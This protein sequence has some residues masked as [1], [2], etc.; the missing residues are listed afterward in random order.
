M[1]AAQRWW[2]HHSLAALRADLARLGVP[3]V[4][5]QGRASVELAALARETGACA[6]HGLHHY[7]P[8]WLQAEEEVAAEALL[9][10]HEGNQL[11]NP[12][13]VL[14]GAGERYRVFTPWFNKL[15]EQFSP[16]PP[17]PRPDRVI[18]PDVV[19]ASD[20]L[21]AWQLKPSKPDWSGG[22]ADWTPGE[23]GARA[24][25]RKFLPSL[26]HYGEQRNFPARPGTSRLSPHI[27]FGEISPATLW[28]HAV[29]REG[30]GARQFLS[31]IAWREHGLNLVDQ[32]PD[33]AQQNGRKVFDGFPWRSGPDADA[34]FAAWTRGRT[35]YPVVDAGMRELWETGWMHNRVRMITASFL[36]KHLLIDWRRGERWFWDT[37][38]DAD[39]GANAMNWQYVAGSGVDAPV[40]SRIMAPLLQSEKFDMAG[41]IRRFVPE[42]AHLQDDEIHDP[43]DLSRAAA[44]YPFPLIA[45]EAA[46]ARALSAWDACRNG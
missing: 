24:A 31:E 3:L 29:S 44:G 27:H 2:L 6:I 23:R 39:L 36:V 33:Y 43:Q 38:L 40:F 16:R 8:W 30:A 25:F 4:L 5:R 37:L 14:N 26:A 15:F 12:R 32:M 22:F 46:R 20:E 42:I 21:D 13:S 34:D 35:G 17:M 18:S 41:Y 9:I 1:G 7:E 28:H 10:L 11:A 45:H 19:P